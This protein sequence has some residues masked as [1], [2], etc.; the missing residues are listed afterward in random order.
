VNIP[1]G[2]LG[3]VLAVG[4]AAGVGVVTLFAFGVTALAGRRDATDAAGSDRAR[5]GRSLGWAIIALCGGLVLF[6]IYLAIPS[7]HALF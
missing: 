3:L 2:D 4:L 7:L 6:G 5:P 1:W